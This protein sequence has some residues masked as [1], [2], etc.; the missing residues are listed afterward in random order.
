[1]VFAYRDS[2][3][4]VSD[5]VCTQNTSSHAHLSQSCQSSHR[6]ALVHAHSCVW[7]KGQLGSSFLRA[8]SKRHL[9]LHAMSL[10]GVPRVSSFCSTHPPTWRLESDQPRAQLRGWVDRLVIWPTPFNPQVTS[11]RPASASAVSTRQ[12]TSLQ[13]ETVSTLRMT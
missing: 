9:H 7:P 11:P 4:L 2:D 5:G 1:M 12:S 10:L 3:S 8:F 13:E 6:N